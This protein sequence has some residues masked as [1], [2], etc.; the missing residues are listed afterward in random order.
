MNR[1]LKPGNWPS[2][3]KR[4]IPCSGGC[5]KI[6]VKRTNWKCNDCKNSVS[7][8]KPPVGYPVQCSRCCLEFNSTGE[9]CCPECLVISV[10]TWSGAYWNG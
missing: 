1:I 7:A 9:E 5:G 6:K 10:P 8:H 4:P 3:V 2:R